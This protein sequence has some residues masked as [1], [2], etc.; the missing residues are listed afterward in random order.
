M[1]F[2]LEKWDLT[3]SSV[4]VTD[5]RHVDM[6]GQ[7]GNIDSLMLHGQGEFCDGYIHGKLCL[8]INRR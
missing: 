7:E 2:Q 1:Y 5:W 4:F 3:D 6:V 8:L